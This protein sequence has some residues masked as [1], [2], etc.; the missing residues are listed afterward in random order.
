MKVSTHAETLE[1]KIGKVKLQNFDRKRTHWFK[2]KKEEEKE[3]EKGEMILN[4]D[5]K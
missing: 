5:L 4:Y 3:N 2:S 1:T